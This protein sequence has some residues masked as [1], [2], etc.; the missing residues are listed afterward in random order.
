MKNYPLSSNCCNWIFVDHIEN[1]GA[2]RER[3][4]YNKAESI[5]VNVDFILSHFRNRVFP[6]TISTFKTRGKQRL[7]IDREILAPQFEKA[8]G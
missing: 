6:R 7:S 1:K 3:M 2:E 4:T 8:C 5:S